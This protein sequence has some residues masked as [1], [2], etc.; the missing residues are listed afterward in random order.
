MPVH[1]RRHNKSVPV[2]N[3]IL[4]NIVVE[5]DMYIVT[6]F[7]PYSGT[8]DVLIKAKTGEMT[9]IRQVY[10]GRRC[11]QIKRGISDFTGNGKFIFEPARISQAIRNRRIQ[12]GR[13]R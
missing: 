1:C 12:P 7:L 11:R 5:P 8:R 13:K 9:T 4:S 10:L 2:N 3:A 6:S